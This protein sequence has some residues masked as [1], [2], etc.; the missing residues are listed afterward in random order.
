MP[1]PPKSPP[2][3]RPGRTWTTSQRAA[4]DHTAGDLLVSAAAG[5]GKTAV[6]AERCAQLVCA[7]NGTSAETRTGVENLLV[8]TFTKAAAN[9]MRSRIAH[10]L[11]QTLHH[12]THSKS[13]NATLH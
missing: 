7:T 4:I 9:E 10:A 13:P 5:S 6:L 3:S 1:P 2:H 8:L 12:H 11:R